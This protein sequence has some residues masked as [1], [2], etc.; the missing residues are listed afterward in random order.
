MILWST[1]I[2]SLFSSQLELNLNWIVWILIE[3]KYQIW[4][5]NELFIKHS[6]ENAQWTAELRLKNKIRK[7]K[8]F[9]PNNLTVANVILHV[10]VFQSWTGQRCERLDNDLPKRQHLFATH[11]KKKTMR[12]HKR[13][14]NRRRSEAVCECVFTWNE[15]HLFEIQEEKNRLYLLKL[16]CIHKYIC[17]Y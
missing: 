9:K 15:L 4:S 8:W 17:E 2:F 7:T 1:S 13:M 11:S 5:L 10:H 14:T 3:K 12:T 16:I 6:A